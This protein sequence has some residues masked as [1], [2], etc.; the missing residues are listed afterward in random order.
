M[1]DAATTPEANSQILTGKLAQKKTLVGRMG[2]GSRIK[3]YLSALT[4]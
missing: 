3:L 1:S 2:K 4:P